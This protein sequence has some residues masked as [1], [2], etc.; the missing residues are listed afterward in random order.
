LEQ[1]AQYLRD[2][3]N[4]M[5]QQDIPGGE[6]TLEQVAREFERLQRVLDSQRLR[7]EA[8]EQISALQDS[9]GGNPGEVGEGEEVA[10]QTGGEG[11]GS[12]GDGADGTGK[13]EG[14][15]EGEGEAQEGGNGEGE[16]G[17]GG[18]RGGER[19]TEKEKAE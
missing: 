6:K 5:R 12:G 16:D 2:T 10:A 13:G 15:G 3:S 19:V 9:M 4:A 18:G 1:L 8:S 14:Q 11:E 7:S 17:E